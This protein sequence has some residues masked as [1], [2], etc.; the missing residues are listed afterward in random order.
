MSPIYTLTRPRISLPF[1]PF[2]RQPLL[3]SPVQSCI[4]PHQVAGGGCKSGAG[5]EGGAHPPSRP[6]TLSSVAYLAT[7]AASLGWRTTTWTASRDTPLPCTGEVAGLTCAF[8]L[9]PSCGAG[10]SPGKQANNEP[11]TVSWID[12]CSAIA[13]WRLFCCK[14]G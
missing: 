6:S 5:Q 9:L 1:L 12:A 14:L 4:S 3:S 13:R 8:A 11:R 10:C 2:G 7:S